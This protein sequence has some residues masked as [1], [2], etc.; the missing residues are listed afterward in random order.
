MWVC[1]RNVQL[2]CIYVYVLCMCCSD[3]S[4]VMCVYCWRTNNPIYH[5]DKSHVMYVYWRCITTCPIQ[6]YITLTKVMWCTCTAEDEQS[7]LVMYHNLSNPVIYQQLLL[8]TQLI[9]QYIKITIS[10]W[11]SDVS[12]CWNHALSDISKWCI[13]TKTALHPTDP[14]IHQNY[15]K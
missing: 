11:E 9:Q 10:S 12:L 5:S 7:A 1:Q 8:C 14:A 3:K 15:H 13:T 6:W 2:C 4:H